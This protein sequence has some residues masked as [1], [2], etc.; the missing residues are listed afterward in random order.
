ME[1]VKNVLGKVSKWVWLVLAGVVIAFVA[2]KKHVEAEMSK[3]GV[4]QEEDIKQDAAVKLEK[5]IAKVEVEKVEK[6]EKVESEKKEKE[7]KLESEKK[8][9]TD[10]LKKSSTEELKKEAA[11]TLGV[12]E[13]KKGRPKKA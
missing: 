10:K 4:T 13:K 5:E 12:K 8:E 11:K 3:H 2:W 7:V 9:K 1:T 6:I